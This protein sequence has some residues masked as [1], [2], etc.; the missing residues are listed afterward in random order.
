M[1]LRR[2]RAVLILAIALIA[3][4]AFSSA[5]AASRCVAMEDCAPQVS[6]P[7]PMSSSMSPCE[8]MSGDCGQAAGP[9]IVCEEGCARVFS[10]APAVLAVAPGAPP[11]S[12]AH[13]LIVPAIDAPRASFVSGATLAPVSRGR[14][15]LYLST[16]SLLI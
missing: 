9:R 1:S 11:A 6:S 8:G 14:P 7:C 5:W 16:H 15:A 12:S 2:N 13:V 10:K 4:G 3:Q